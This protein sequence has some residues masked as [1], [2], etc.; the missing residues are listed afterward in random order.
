MHLNAGMAHPAHNSSIIAGTVS[1]LSSQTSFGVWVKEA[2]MLN[3][4]DRQLYLDA[5]KPPVGY[6]LDRAVA[7]TFSLDLT[8]L[9]TVPLGFALL[10]WDD[11]QGRL[12]L[13]PVALLHSLRKYADRITVFCQ[14]GRI[15]TPAKQ[16]PL[17]AHLERMIVE[18]HAAKPHGVF[19]PKV[20]LLRFLSKEAP[21]RYRLL[22]MSRNLTSD[23]SWDTLLTLEG[24]LAD[25]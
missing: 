6:E 24:D 5:L 3:P 18:V 19:H 10:D 23:R 12:L 4:L 1:A 11:S 15:A 22:C 20:W 14:A 21:V 17:F 16:H 13:D 2:H 7:T 8:T 9:L 25:R